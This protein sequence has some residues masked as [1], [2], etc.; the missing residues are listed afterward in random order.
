MQTQ[1][2]RTNFAT[3]QKVG[4]IKVTRA[5]TTTFVGTS[6]RHIM[7]VY[8]AKSELKTTRLTFH[9]V[10]HAVEFSSSV[11]WPSHECRGCKC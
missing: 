4:F 5:A 7:I 3:E 9:I 11:R 8:S 2:S 1:T 10:E 6:L